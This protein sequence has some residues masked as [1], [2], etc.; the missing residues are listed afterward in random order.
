VAPD[1]RSRPTPQQGGSQNLNQDQLTPYAAAWAEYVVAGWRGPIPIATSWR[2]QPSDGKFPPPAGFTGKRNRDTW[3]TLDQMHEWAAQP[4][5]W[6]NIA[7]RLP[8]DVIG[9]DVDAYGEKRGRAT[10]TEALERWG[11]LPATWISGSRTDGR[12]GIYWF[13]TPTG[14]Q[15]PGKLPG[16]DVEIIQHGHRYAIVWPSLHPAGRTYQWFRGDIGTPADGTVPGPDDFPHLPAAWVAGLTQGKTVTRRPSVVVNETMGDHGPEHLDARRWLTGGEPCQAVTRAL[17]GFDGTSRHDAMIVLQVRLLRLGEQGHRGVRAA[18]DTLESMF[19]EA[20][21]ADGTRTDSLA[22]DEWQRA[23][24]G[25]PAEIL[26]KGLTP[27]DRRGCCP[28]P[29]P[30]LDELAARHGITTA[31]GDLATVWEP[32]DDKA[33][34]RLFVATVEEVPA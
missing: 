2:G 4:H 10:M 32:L 31:P 27:A 15:W 34:T 3:P 11:E 33:A 13:R 26:A 5:A 6:R 9:L 21:T 1:A 22:A 7:L 8:D 23:L 29:V 19:V 28:E 25:A 14:L 30:T 18:I 20:V 16:G 12:S 24:N 17:D